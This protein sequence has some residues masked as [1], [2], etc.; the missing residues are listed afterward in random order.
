MRG[1]THAGLLAASALL[2]F[3]GMPAHAHSTE[4]E[5]TE[6]V[7]IWMPNLE[8]RQSVIGAVEPSEF[9][10]HVIVRYLRK[11][12][13]GWAQKEK[14]RVKLSE[15]SDTRPRLNLFTT[16]FDQVTKKGRCKVT[17]RYPGTETLAPSSTQQI[18]DCPSGYVYE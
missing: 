12:P 15:P 7:I 14:L 6:T 4:R 17:V 9:G 8:G 3:A 13:S 10:T 2:A 16:T 1:K 18:L 5:S 11:T